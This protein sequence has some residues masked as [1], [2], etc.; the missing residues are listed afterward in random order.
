MPNPTGRERSRGAGS[1]A[2]P[3]LLPHPPGREALPLSLPHEGVEV[4]QELEPVRGHALVVGRQ[5]D[6]LLGQGQRRLGLLQPPSDQHLEGVGR[7]PVVGL[8]RARYRHLFQETEL[9]QKPGAG[10]GRRLA[11]P[12]R[13]T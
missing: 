7:L 9:F 6:T 4:A 1:S 8:P 3:L 5:V 10:A 2:A 11:D 12:Q 13:S